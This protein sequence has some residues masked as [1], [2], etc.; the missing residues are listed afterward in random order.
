MILA[1]TD[2]F[3]RQVAVRHQHRQQRHH[4]EDD[5]EEGGK[6]IDGEQAAGNRRLDMQVA[7]DRAQRGHQHRQRHAGQQRA[8]RRRQHVGDEHRQRP[9]REHD[10]GEQVP[11]VAGRQAGRHH[12]GAPAV[13]ESTGLPVVSG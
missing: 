4:Q 2:P 7:D 8:A 6:A 10:L 12:R 1:S 5:L 13:V 11:E 3:H 9:D